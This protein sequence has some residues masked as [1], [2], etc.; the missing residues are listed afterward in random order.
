MWDREGIVDDR[1]TFF[2]SHAAGWDEMLAQ[3]GRMQKY[4]GVVEW[5]GVR[6]GESIL[7]VGTGTGVLLLFLRH[8]AG[9]KGM[10]VAMDFSINML[11]Q[12]MN[13]QLED[14]VALIN[15]GV[16]AIP[17][18]SEQFDKV[19]C[20]SAFPHFPDKQ[21]ALAE[22]VR[23]LRRGGIVSIAHLQSIEELA[24]VHEKT[25]G[26]VRGDHLP[27]H[28]TMERLMTN[29]GLTGITIINEPGKYLTQGR[30]G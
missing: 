26:P 2:D 4:A 6:E 28:E 16:G 10:V 21:K 30:K 8:A 18:K 19:T 24:S 29:A 13:R 7:D 22:M 11:K 1:K 9:H 14:K 3:D 23:V 25:G 5:F 17:F 20:F 15:A 12:A 27:N